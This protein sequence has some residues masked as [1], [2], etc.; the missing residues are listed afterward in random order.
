MQEMNGYN[1]EDDEKIP[2][3]YT[4]ILEAYRNIYYLTR[5][6]KMDYYQKD[7]Y[8]KNNNTEDIVNGDLTNHPT[9]FKNFKTFHE[10][11]IECVMKLNEEDTQFIKILCDL[12]LH[13]RLQIIPNYTM[14]HANGLYFNKDGTLVISHPR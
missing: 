9:L 8:S 2:R 4:E 7:F 3:D 6:G 11:N 5:I 1:S 13:R 10:W 14:W 12:I